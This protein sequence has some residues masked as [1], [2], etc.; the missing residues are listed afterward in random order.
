MRPSP[1]TIKNE[2]FKIE[3]INNESKEEGKGLVISDKEYL[4]SVF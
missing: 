4:K 1:W 3:Y 2:F